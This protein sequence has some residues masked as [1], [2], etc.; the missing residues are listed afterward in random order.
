VQ[1][2]IEKHVVP[3]KVL[4]DTVASY[5]AGDPGAE[6]AKSLA[7][8]AGRVVEVATRVVGSAKEEFIEFSNSTKRVR[9]S[10]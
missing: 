1:E 4:G 10:I 6:V 3:L 2:F 9:L 7:V 5:F 8:A